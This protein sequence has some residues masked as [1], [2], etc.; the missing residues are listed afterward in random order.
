MYEARDL[1]S[2]LFML[3][4]LPVFAAVFLVSLLLYAPLWALSRAW[5]WLNAV[6]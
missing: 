2:F 4:M 1:G 5:R 3:L 6:P